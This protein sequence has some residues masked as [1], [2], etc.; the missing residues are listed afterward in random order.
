MPPLIPFRKIHWE[1]LVELSNRFKYVSHLEFSGPGWPGPAEEFQPGAL[2]FRDTT[3]NDGSWFPF[4]FNYNLDSLDIT[5]P[6]PGP[7][8]NAWRRSELN[9][10]EDRVEEVWD[11]A[12]TSLPHPWPADD[13]KIS[14]PATRGFLDCVHWSPFEWT[15]DWTRSNAWDPYIYAESDDVLDFGNSH[16][17]TQVRTTGSGD[18]FVTVVS[19]QLHQPHTGSVQAIPEEM[20]AGISGAKLTWL[21]PVASCAGNSGRRDLP[22][23][24][25]VYP[26]AFTKQSSYWFVPVATWPIQ[27]D[28]TCIL[29]S[30][31][32]SSVYY[33]DMIYV[34]PP[35]GPPQVIWIITGTAIDTKRMALAIDLSDAE[36]I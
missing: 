12:N 15:Y 2:R 35:S 16:Y 28:G 14:I 33:R 7:Y 34:D 19:T 22:G 24:V 1:L 18:S 11:L 23:P 9:P 27:T 5:T 25:G 20:A 3:I 31:S 4:A 13:T 26:V 8:A 30:A 6:D 10:F 21:V 29:S 32:H 17:D 36:F